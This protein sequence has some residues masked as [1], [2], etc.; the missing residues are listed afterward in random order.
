[1]SARV[2]RQWRPT[3]RARN[4]P[5]SIPRVSQRSGEPMLS[6]HTSAATSVKLNVV[7]T[8]RPPSHRIAGRYVPHHGIAWA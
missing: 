7:V 6:P 4:R 8:M 3:L 5:D 1:M 2:M